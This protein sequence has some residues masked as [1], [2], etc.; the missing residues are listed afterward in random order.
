MKRCIN[1]LLAVVM[2]FTMFSV[3][4]V[5]T[6]AAV[7]NTCYSYTLGELAE[8]EYTSM[9]DFHKF[10]IAK[11]TKVKVE[12]CVP[13]EQNSTYN[14]GDVDFSFARK[15]D[16]EVEDV[17][18]S[19]YYDFKEE[20]TVKRGET[21]EAE[22]ILQPGKYYFVAKQ[23]SLY[24]HRYQFKI[25]VLEEVETPVHNNVV[26]NGNEYDVTYEVGTEFFAHNYQYERSNMY[27]YFNVAHKT[28]FDLKVKTEKDLYFDNYTYKHSDTVKVQRDIND[29]YGKY[30]DVESYVVNPGE[31]ITKTFT[32][33]E[34]KYRIEMKSNNGNRGDFTLSLVKGALEASKI[35]FKDKT[36]TIER[37]TSTYITAITTPEDG[38]ANVTYKSSNT[39]VATV[40]ERGWVTGVKD[41]TATITATLQNGAKAT[42]KVVVKEM[43]AVAEVVSQKNFYAYHNKNEVLL[44]F[45][46]YKDTYTDATYIS[47][48]DIN[49]VKRTF[50]VYRSNKKNGKYKYMG[51]VSYN[52]TV[53]YNEFVDKKVKPNTKY[54]YKVQVKVHG[55]GDF[56]PMSKAVEYWT[57]PNPTVKVK[58]NTFTKATWKKVKK[59]TG[60]IA[61]E[62]CIR[63]EGYNIF[64]Q[65]VRSSITAAKMTTK[66]SFAK[67]YYYVSKGGAKSKSDFSV[68][69]YGKHGKYYYV[70]GRIVTKYKSDLEILKVDK[71]VG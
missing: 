1:F 26:K 5:E 43:K 16:G 54:Y 27:F 32:L 17:A 67:K 29:K 10:E 39:K 7:V 53:G 52:K 62:H 42:I 28:Q 59:T 64:G 30:S 6:D 57:T 4:P 69:T 23:S 55:D 3:N 12:M 37:G 38:T 22:V 60:Y 48:L 61:T 14:G 50:K 11:R 21:Q 34:G 8:Y 63:F 51:S 56:G 36:A 15:K 25:S 35:S 44:N 47:D 45:T 46:P 33:D 58:S 71:L 40:N 49:R 66:T 19:K 68:T 2:L 13:S 31:E 9:S 18:D 70:S 20:F 65:E 24:K 41:G